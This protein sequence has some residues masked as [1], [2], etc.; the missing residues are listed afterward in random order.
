[1][2]RFACR[3][4]WSALPILLGGPLLPLACGAE[5][6]GVLWNAVVALDA[7]PGQFPRTVEEAKV[8]YTKHVVVQEGAVRRFLEAAPAGDSR[9]FEAQMR[10]ARV[11]T[12]RA[13]L[14]GKADIQTES[15]RILDKLEASGSAEQRAE[16]GFTRISQW[17]RRNRFPDAVQR[18]ELLLAVKEFREKFPSD[19]RVARL[20]VEVATRFD[21][22]P[23]VKGELLATASRATQDAGL[24]KRIADDQ[25][26]L[27]LL[28]KPLNLKFTDLNGRQ[29][30][31]EDCRNRPVVVLYFAANSQPSLEA[32][33]AVGETLR[34]YPEAV[35]VGI[36]LDEDRVAMERVRK[37]F[38]E[39]WVIAWDGRGWMSS[40]ARRWGVN[41]L[42][43]VW[44]V[45]KKGVLVSLDALE[46]LPK[47]LATLQ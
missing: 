33:K 45:D 21:R 35:R 37:V 6:A 5:D 40:L 19:R 39:N 7:G 25:A 36:S 2:S 10:L 8:L 4:A 3:W 26:R 42:P 34:K 27:E 47:Q 46:E 22:E 11:L 31:M 16:V 23:A 12:I 32:W 24:K 28:G 14:E 13:E 43:T 1:M 29:F 15:A 18:Q 30:R 44:L 9:L 41:V 17:M 20:L 38:G